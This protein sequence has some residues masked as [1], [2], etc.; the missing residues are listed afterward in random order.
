[1]FVVIKLEGN[2]YCQMLIN[3]CNNFIC[4]LFGI[5]YE[6]IYFGIFKMLLW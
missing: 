2:N 3:V 1:M 6:D 4:R 5:L